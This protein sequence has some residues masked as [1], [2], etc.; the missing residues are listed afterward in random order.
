MLWMRA[1][2]ILRQRLAIAKVKYVCRVPDFELQIPRKL[3]LAFFVPTFKCVA[4]KILF[5]IK[6]GQTFSYPKNEFSIITENKNSIAMREAYA[7][8]LLPPR[9][10]KFILQP[11]SG[12]DFIRYLLLVLCRTISTTSNIP[13]Y[14]SG[15]G[16]IVR[17]YDYWRSTEFVYYCRQ[18]EER[19]LS[20]LESDHCFGVYKRSSPHWT[21]I[22]LLN[23][24]RQCF[25]KTFHRQ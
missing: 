9:L 21:S 16:F 8:K 10:I 20:N 1:N 18:N 4:T 24:F 19:K 11:I 15:G 5:A 14:E 7:N 2:P 25:D 23:R 3:A 13:P 22:I 17:R 6:V 12:V